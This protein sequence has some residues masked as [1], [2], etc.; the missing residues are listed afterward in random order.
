MK[1]ILDPKNLP[2][3]GAAVQAVLFSI[4][5]NKLFP[6]VGWLV[7]LGVGI[8]V[9][10]SLAMA[11][12]RVSDVAK[13]RKVL[14]YIA[15][16]GLLCISPVII[17]STLGWTVANF[18]WSV[19]CDASIVLTGSIVGK[20]LIPTVGAI[21]RPQRRPATPSVTPAI[22]AK[23]YLCE[24]GRRDFKNRFEFSGHQG[25]CATHK[26]ALTSKAEALFNTQ[27]KVRK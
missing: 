27:V 9:N 23:E 22:P 20:S 13:N 7:G 19:A 18:S 17:C 24:C 12:S 4:A 16:A 26:E 21:K 8:V 15:L 2:Y 5:G 3:L 1:K 6:Y 14:A 11:S 10:W 25:K